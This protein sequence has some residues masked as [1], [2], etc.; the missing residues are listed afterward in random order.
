MTKLTF[1][2]NEVSIADLSVILDELVG[3]GNYSLAEE[4]NPSVGDEELGFEPVTLTIIAVGIGTQV[5]ANLLTDFIKSKLP[6]RK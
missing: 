3:P 6:K 5:V 4:P 1:N 2:P